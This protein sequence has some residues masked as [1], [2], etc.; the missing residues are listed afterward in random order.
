MHRKR[1]TSSGKLVMQRGAEGGSGEGG[2]GCGDGGGG[3]GGEG[4]GEGGEGGGGDCSG[5]G[6]GDCVGDGGGGGGFL[7]KAHA[8]H[9]H[10]VQWCFLYVMSHQVSHCGCAH[11]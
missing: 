7:Q 2:G 5:A 10:L 4:G 9:L 8:R 11:L 6:G 3:E 1:G